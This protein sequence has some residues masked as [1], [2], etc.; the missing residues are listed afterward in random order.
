MS[1][2]DFWN[3]PLVVTSMRLKFRKGSPALAA[4]MYA[5]ALL[6]IGGVLHYIDTQG[7]GLPIAFGRAYLVA[8]FGVQFAVSGGMAL[9]GVAA[10]MTAEVANRTL[11]FQRI[12]SLSPRQIMLGKMLGDPALSYFFAVMTIPFAAICLFLGGGSAAVVL[13]MYVNLA[14][15]TL[16]AAAGGLMHTLVLPENSPQRNRGS[17]A[18]MF[19]MVLFMV[20]WMAARSGAVLGNPWLATPLG[21][22]TPIPSLV[23]QAQ[24]DAFSATVPLWGLS[25]P[26]LL[27]A[28]VA[29]L[30]VAWWIVAAMARR[31]RSTLDPPLKR[32]RV[33]AATAVVDV[34]AA[35][36]CYAEWQRGIPLTDGVYRYCL[37]HLLALLVITPA[38]T[39]SHAAATSW[40]WRGRMFSSAWRDWLGGNRSP[41]VGM[42]AVQAALCVAIFLAAAWAPACL[43]SPNGW[44]DFTEIALPL[45]TTGLT[46]LAMASLYQAMSVVSAKSGRTLAVFLIAMIFIL[47][48]IA[49]A[50]VRELPNGAGADSILAISPAAYLL[51]NMSRFSSPAV[52][53]VATLVASLGV[54]AVSMAVLRRWVARH[55]RIVAAKLAKMG[56]EPANPRAADAVIR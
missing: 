55:G 27:A 37:A 48:P 22:L 3:N 52:L 36:V 13:A 11:D 17:F 56:V 41:A 10:S 8:I 29:Q 5:I 32:S 53:P 12:V 26:S 2:W 6:G 28:P 24:G 54:L 18:G 4:S 30:A 34:L 44:T 40:L 50:V 21:L 39:P 25:V 38:A 47:P 1:G 9:F 20:P 35:A 51:S 43:S 49:A 42:Y 45:I 23:R 7:P 16:M 19:M 46:G 31:L 15:F 14:T 33:Y